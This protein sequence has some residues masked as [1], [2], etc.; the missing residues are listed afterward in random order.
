MWPINSQTSLH[1]TNQDIYFKLKSKMG[2]W[3]LAKH[4]TCQIRQTKQTAAAQLVLLC[5]MTGTCAKLSPAHKLHL[6]FIS[7]FLFRFTQI[8]IYIL[9]H[10]TPEGTPRSSHPLTIGIQKQT[11]SIHH[12]K[13]ILTQTLTHATSDFEI[14]ALTDSSQ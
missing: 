9:M 5:C 6:V 2:T 8:D 13:P 10:L 11:H 3:A 14:T 7:L 12:S 1:C 4:V